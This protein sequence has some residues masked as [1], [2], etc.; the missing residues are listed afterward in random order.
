MWS[1]AWTRGDTGCMQWHDPMQAEAGHPT[2]KHPRPHPLSQPLHIHVS[3]RP[4]L[5]SRNRVQLT[6][7]V[8]SD[9]VMSPAT[10]RS[11]PCAPPSTPPRT[12]ICCRV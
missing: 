9:P 5:K 8:P 3:A 1:H 11:F 7:L 10:Y 12:S 4:A 6:I 2:C